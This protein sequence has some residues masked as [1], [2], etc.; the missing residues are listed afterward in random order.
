MDT[1]K[2]NVMIRPSKD[3]GYDIAFGCTK[4]KNYILVFAV[5]PYICS[6]KKEMM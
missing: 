1:V 4:G 6:G 5:S 2:K 3:S